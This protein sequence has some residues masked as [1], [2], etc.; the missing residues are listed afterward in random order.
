MT[1][2]WP[3]SKPEIRPRL[4]L[5]AVLS[6]DRY[7]FASEAVALDD[8]DQDMIKTGIYQSRQVTPG[9]RIPESEYGW[10]EHSARRVS[11]VQRSHLR[12]LLADIGFELK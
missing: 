12:G 5:G 10:K 3:E 6:W 9:N 1:L 11:K 7:K 8:Y 4:P 2:G